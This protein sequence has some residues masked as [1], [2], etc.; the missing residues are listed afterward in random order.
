MRRAAPGKGSILGFSPP[1]FLFFFRHLQWLSKNKFIFQQHRLKFQK[2][3]GMENHLFE[4]RN[5]KK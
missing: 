5:R 3:S 4:V 2:K 1:A